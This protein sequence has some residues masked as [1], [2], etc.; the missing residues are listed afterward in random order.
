M[1]VLFTS[2]HCM[3][4]ENFAVFLISKASTGTNQDGSKSEKYNVLPRRK[5]NSKANENQTNKLLKK[6]E[7]SSALV[8]SDLS[9]FLC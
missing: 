6:C 9:F 5:I 4:N 1:T 7:S 8:T 2:C 3:S